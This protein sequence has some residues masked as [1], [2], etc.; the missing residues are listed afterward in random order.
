MLGP[1]TQIDT[2]SALNHQNLTNMHSPCIVV[3]VQVLLQ[4]FLIFNDYY[5]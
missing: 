2:A 3:F 5:T 4:L 1:I